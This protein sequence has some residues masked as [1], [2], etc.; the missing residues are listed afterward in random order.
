MWIAWHEQWLILSC[1][2]LSFESTLTLR[3]DWCL[4]HWDVTV[5]CLC[6]VGEG[7]AGEP[8]RSRHWPVV[9][10]LHRQCNGELQGKYFMADDFLFVPVCS[11]NISWWEWRHPPNLTVSVV[12]ISGFLLTGPWWVHGWHFPQ[13]QELQPSRVWGF[14]QRWLKSP[15]WFDWS[16]CT[17][18][19][20]YWR[21]L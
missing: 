21:L 12:W 9:L 5:L 4:A 15:V 11:V 16:S 6:A 14:S 3:T 19:N 13:C 10:W 8:D 1:V 2:A 17:G 18:K 20:H 7:Y